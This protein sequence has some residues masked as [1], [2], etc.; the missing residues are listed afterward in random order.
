MSQ[1]TYD[2]GGGALGIEVAKALCYKPEGRRLP[3]R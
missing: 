2:Q 3:T 1:G